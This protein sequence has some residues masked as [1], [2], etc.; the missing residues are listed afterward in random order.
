MSQLCQLGFE[1]IISENT[2]LELSLF[3]YKATMLLTC[4]GMCPVRI[5]AGALTTLTEEFVAFLSQSK[6]ITE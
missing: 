1:P 3:S 6:K 5:L 2:S 4:T